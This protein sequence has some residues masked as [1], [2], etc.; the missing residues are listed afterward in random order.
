MPISR[1]DPIAAPMLL[2]RVA[3]IGGFAGVL[4]A[5]AG[6]EPVLVDACPPA[7]IAVPADR[8]GNANADGELRFVV[9]MDD[10][11]SSC[12]HDGETVL[13]DLDFVVT[14]SP[15]PGLDVESVP[16]SY[17]LATI[18]PARKIVDKQVVTIE[19]DLGEAET[20]RRVRQELTLRLPVSTDAGGA[21]YSLYVGFQPDQQP[22]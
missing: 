1:Q 19:I 2:L 8:V 10:L 15:G 6:S 16:V 17:F 3:A 13:V 7:Q 12:S 11:A 4:A 5:C 14:A 9:T 21:N 20:E 18:D 22:G